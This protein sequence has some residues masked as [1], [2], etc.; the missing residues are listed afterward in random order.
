M[1][2]TP[3]KVELSTKFNQVP[4]VRSLAAGCVAFGLEAENGTVFAVEIKAKEIS[5]ILRG[6][7]VRQLP[8]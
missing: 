8:F 7:A 5:K 2:T 4:S 1:N 6:E 3:A